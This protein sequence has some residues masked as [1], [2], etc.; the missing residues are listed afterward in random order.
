VFAWRSTDSG[1]TWGRRVQL[2]KTGVNGGFPAAVGTKDGQFR[3]WFAD[4]RT[5]EWNTFYRT[6]Y[7]G[8]HWSHA[9]LLSNETSGASYKS[10]AGYQEFYGDYGEI[11]VTD[12]GKTVAIWGEGPSYRGPGGSWFDRQL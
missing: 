5:G 11:D 2:S 7:D 10:K 9:V 8:V 3:V 1:A 12:T 6:S 4:R